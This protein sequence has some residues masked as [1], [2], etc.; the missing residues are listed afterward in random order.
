MFA[1]PSSPGPADLRAPG[2]LGS[3]PRAWLRNMGQTLSSALCLPG[4]GGL[5]RLLLLAIRLRQ[6][7]INGFGRRLGSPLEPLGHL[8]PTQ[9]CPRL[10]FL[11]GRAGPAACGPRF[12]LILSA[13]GGFARFP[14]FAKNGKPGFHDQADSVRALPGALLFWLA[15]A[16]KAESRCPACCGFHADLCLPRSG[17]PKSIEAAS[18]QPTRSGFGSARWPCPPW[19]HN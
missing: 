12:P 1:S 16:A 18:I 17:R 11:S 15:V 3:N 10:P 5:C 6:P 2:S 13:L 19:R 8:Q 4:I 9:L 7:F 14:G